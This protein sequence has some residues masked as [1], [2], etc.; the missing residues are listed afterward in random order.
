MKRKSYYRFIVKKAEGVAYKDK[1][2]LS[3]C[4]DVRITIVFLCLS[5]IHSQP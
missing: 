1:S 5:Q 2:M 4:A 3:K